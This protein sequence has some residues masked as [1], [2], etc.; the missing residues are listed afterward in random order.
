MA[1]GRSQ[2][3]SSQSRRPRGSNVIVIDEDEDEKESGVDSE[4]DEDVD[5]NDAG[6]SEDSGIVGRRDARQLLFGHRGSM[7]LTSIRRSS[8][9]RRRTDIVYQE[10]ENSDEDSE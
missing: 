1:D 3:A 2:P 6:G 5:E 4:E 9:K 10:R 8:R 7:P